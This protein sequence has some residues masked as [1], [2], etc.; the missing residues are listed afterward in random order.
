MRD[1]A[2]GLLHP[3]VGFDIDQGSVDI[4]QQG[5]NLHH[6]VRKMILASSTSRRRWPAQTQEFRAM[7]SRVRAIWKGKRPVM[8]RKGRPRAGKRQ[9]DSPQE[10]AVQ[11]A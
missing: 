8:E 2:I 7:R 11:R 9:G 3:L 10:G 5:P 6:G 1:G 4:E